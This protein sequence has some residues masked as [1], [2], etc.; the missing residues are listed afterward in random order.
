MRNFSYN[1]G[2]KIKGTLTENDKNIDVEV[3]FITENLPFGT[4]RYGTPKIIISEEYYN[5]AISNGTE[6]DVNVFY[7]SNNP[8]KLQDEIEEYLK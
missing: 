6:R 5:E 2:D 1:R 3:G 8:N 4:N 7:K